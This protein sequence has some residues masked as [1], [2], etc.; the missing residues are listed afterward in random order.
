MLARARPSVV[1][2]EVVSHDH[3]CREHP[4]DPT[5]GEYFGAPPLDG[6]LGS[7]VGS[8]VVAE[9]G[10]FVLTNDHVVASAVGVRVVDAGGRRLRARLVGSDPPTD[11]AVVRVEGADLR[12]ARFASGGRLRVG[13]R[14][15]AFGVPFGLPLSASSGMVSALPDDEESGFLQTDAPLNPGNSGGPLLDDRGEVVGINL[16][17]LRGAQ[18]IGFAIP[19]AR[20]LR[21]YRAIRSGG[22]VVRGTIGIELQALTPDLLEALGLPNGSGALVADVRPGGPADRAGIRRGDIIRSVG[23]EVV[24]SAEG[25]EKRIRVSAPGVRLR[26]GLLRDRRALDIE[27]AVDPARL[28]PPEVERG[29]VPGHDLGFGVTNLTEA[30]ARDRGLP[31][32]PNARVLVAAV[33]PDS[34]AAEAGLEEEDLI[35]EVDRRAVPDVA[36]FR[37]SVEGRLRPG[38]RFLFL[39]R[40]EGATRYV[41]LTLPPPVP[42]ERI[43]LG[44]GASPVPLYRGAGL[45]NQF[46][47]TRSAGRSWKW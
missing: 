23:T 44:R 45:R 31:W 20:A 34:R 43:A 9:G 11:L 2:V 33:R 4:F 3:V 6:C 46:T 15:F 38:E 1:R 39:V 8:G 25:F 13:D 37:A 12:P 40:R 14:V 7:S 36:S 24:G 10:G 30:L 47:T 5:Q 35:L 19:V 22:G 42:R 29:P 27:V 16:A 41:V 18:G 21:I 28:V 32:D 26:V 17:I